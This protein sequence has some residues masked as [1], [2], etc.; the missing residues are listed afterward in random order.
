MN[1]Y[2]T[3]VYHSSAWEGMVS[4]G[5][6]TAFVEELCGVRVAFMLFVR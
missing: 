2:H 3:V 5:Y 6:I 4:R 1:E